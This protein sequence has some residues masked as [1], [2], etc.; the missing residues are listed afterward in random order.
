MVFSV[1]SVSL[2][3]D[4]VAGKFRGQDQ[5]KQDNLRQAIKIN[6]ILVARKPAFNRGAASSNFHS[7]EKPSSGGI[8]AKAA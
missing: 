2:W 8:S 6:I 3:L 4:S 1:P 7:P 5:A